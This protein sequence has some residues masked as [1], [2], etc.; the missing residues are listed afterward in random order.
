[1]KKGDFM[2]FDEQENKRTLPRRNLYLYLKVIDRKTQ[3]L[4]GR[5]VDLTTDGMMLINEKP[6]E[7]NS[8]ID[9]T[10]ILSDDLI[11]DTT[12]DI[13]VSFTTQWIKPDI[14]PKYYLNGLRFKN[15]ASPKA[16]TIEKVVRK[17]CF[18]EEN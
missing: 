13:K 1:V 9:A 10:I 14:N 2:A 12:A 5:V 4:L 6:F 15:L 7:I 8:S 17:F 11:D 3:E 18:E 16:R